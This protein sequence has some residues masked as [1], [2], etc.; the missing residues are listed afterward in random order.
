MSL[1]LALLQRACVQ[2]AMQTGRR[3]GGYGAWGKQHWPP[4]APGWAHSQVWPGLG[5][6]G[7]CFLKQAQLGQRKRKTGLLVNCFS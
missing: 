6:P 1:L 3:A 4:E 7:L 5:R 2:A